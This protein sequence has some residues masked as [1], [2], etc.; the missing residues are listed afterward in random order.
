[1]TFLFFNDLKCAIKINF[2]NNNTLLTELVHGYSILR[3]DIKPAITGN[4]MV[5]W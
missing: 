5:V 1:M 2:Q 3:I 4:L